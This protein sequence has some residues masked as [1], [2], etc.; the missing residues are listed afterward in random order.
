MAEKR[1]V[2]HLDPEKVAYWYFCLNGFLQIENFVVHP[3]RRG[4]QRVA[5]NGAAR[6]GNACWRRLTEER[7]GGAKSVFHFDV[8]GSVAK[9]THAALHPPAPRRP[10]TSGRSTAGTFRP[11]GLRSP[12]S[13]RRSGRAASRPR[14]APATSTTLPASPPSCRAPIVTAASRRSST[15]ICR[16]PNA[17]WRRSRV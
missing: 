14:A 9:S 4:G 17:R 13:I 3:E 1:M 10:P 15:P 5:G 2:G 6:M 16:R 7:A 12:R 11:D 8:Q